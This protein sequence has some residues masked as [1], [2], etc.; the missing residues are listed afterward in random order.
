[1]KKLD[2]TGKTFGRLLVE[3]FD[4]ALDKWKCLCVCGTRAWVRAAQLRNGRCKSCGCYRVERG[5]LHGS[6]IQR[7]HGEGSNGAES[8]EYRTWAAMKSRCQNPNHSLF[9]DYGGRG[10]R[11]CE[12]WQ[13]F[14]DFLA[15]MGRRPAGMHGKRALYSLDRINNDGHYE[16][17][18]CRWATSVE[19]NNNRRPDVERKDRETDAVTKRTLVHRLRNGWPEELA[20]STPA[21][22]LRH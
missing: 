9:A 18:N 21:R 6:T 15:D 17:G 4:Y 14:E 1:M 3:D 13:K 8:P 12:R 2:L 20:R 11:V 7:R 10:I 5:R 16:P 22:K 19:Q